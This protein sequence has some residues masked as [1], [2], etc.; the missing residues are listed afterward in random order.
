LM[1]VIETEL[2][3]LGE[4]GRVIKTTNDSDT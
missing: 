2:E 4:S 1:K 3:R